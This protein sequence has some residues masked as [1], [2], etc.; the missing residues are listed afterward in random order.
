MGAPMNLDSST[1]NPS[2]NGVFA[3]DTRTNI[4]G[5]YSLNEISNPDL[6]PLVE[7][8]STSNKNPFI[9]FF[10]ENPFELADE[11]AV[12]Q[13]IGLLQILI[14]R[15]FLF[16]FQLGDPYQCSFYE[17]VMKYLA[18]I[19]TTDHAEKVFKKSDFHS[20]I[21]KAFNG[22]VA[23]PN[24]QFIDGSDTAR[25]SL[26]MRGDWD[27]SMPESH[28]FELECVPYASLSADKLCGVLYSTLSCYNHCDYTH[29]ESHKEILNLTLSFACDIARKMGLLISSELPSLVPEINGSTPFMLV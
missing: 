19:S 2:D 7:L 14:H 6:L 27:P 4:T 17:L 13:A 29:T 1:L 15:P 3:I 11:D 18:V 28:T 5:F 22:W 21:I 24:M 10:P 26:F 25:F 9:A 12:M 16:D 8:D 23:N 20:Q